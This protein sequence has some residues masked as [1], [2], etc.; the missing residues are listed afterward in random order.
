MDYVANPDIQVNPATMCNEKEFL[1]TCRRLINEGTRGDIEWMEGQC[2]KTCPPPCK[3]KQEKK[4]SGRLQKN[5][6]FTSPWM[7]QM[8]QMIRKMAQNNI[9]E[10]RHP[11]ESIRRGITKDIIKN[12]LTQF[13][14]RKIAE[15]EGE[16][17][18]GRQ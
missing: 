3:E 9:L 1:F 8:I 13:Y 17:E 4:K 5:L 11:R 6:S 15:T 2:S 7:I 12:I 18:E 10:R 16:I 14:S